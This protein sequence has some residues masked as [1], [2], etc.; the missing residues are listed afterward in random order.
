MKKIYVR[1]ETKAIE[2]DLCGMLCSSG[3]NGNFSGDAATENAKARFIDDWEE[4]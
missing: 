4:E 1:P 3:V 2:I